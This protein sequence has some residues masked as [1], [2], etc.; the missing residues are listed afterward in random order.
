MLCSGCPW[1]PSVR[2][3]RGILEEIV[4][5]CLLPTHRAELIFTL[6]KPIASLLRSA[7][8]EE[9]VSR[10]QEADEIPDT[11]WKDSEQLLHSAR[12]LQGLS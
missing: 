2:H 9:N 10:S 8:S 6:R 4:S 11:T 5:G 7:S 3:Y 12:C 1:S